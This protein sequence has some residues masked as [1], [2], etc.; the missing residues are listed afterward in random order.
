[1]F[2]A[3]LDEFRRLA[4]RWGFVPVLLYTPSAYTACEG[5][6]IFDDPGIELTMRNYSSSSTVAEA[7]YF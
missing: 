3:G 1:L 7:K 2:D 4:G 5:M 6:T